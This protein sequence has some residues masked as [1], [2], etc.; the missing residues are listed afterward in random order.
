V[1]APL[2]V[3]RW[4]DK[5]QFIVFRN[6]VSGC[7]LEHAPADGTTILRLLAHISAYAPSVSIASTSSAGVSAAVSAVAVPTPLT[8]TVRLA[9]VCLVSRRWRLLRRSGDQ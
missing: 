5:H 8:R 1:I 6:G 4:F 3:I 9:R 7:N 2:H